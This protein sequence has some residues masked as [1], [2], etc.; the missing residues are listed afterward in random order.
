MGDSDHKPWPPGAAVHPSMRQFLVDTL[1]NKPRDVHDLIGSVV[2]VDADE[3]EGRTAN[4]Y[5]LVSTFTTS[6]WVFPPCYDDY[7]QRPYAGTKDMSKQPAFGVVTKFVMARS[8]DAERDE[9]RKR[10]GAAEFD[11][12]RCAREADELRAVK[13]AVEKE[14][15]EL[16]DERDE[17]RTGREVGQRAAR[18]SAEHMRKLEED[19]AKVRREVGEKEWK[20][21]TGEG[22]RDP[23]YRREPNQ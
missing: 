4:G 11:A 8:K 7:N 1:T 5:A 6:A 12:N 19:L 15:D 14:R 9:L 21:I 18:A 23:N 16:R 22:P 10:L 3:V 17:L 2:V 13:A 20:R